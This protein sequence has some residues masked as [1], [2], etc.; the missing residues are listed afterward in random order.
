MV[1]EALHPRFLVILLHHNLQK[2]SPPSHFFFEEKKEETRE[3]KRKQNWI[4]ENEYENY[5]HL[6]LFNS[7]PF[8]I[9]S[10]ERIRANKKCFSFLKK[11]KQ[12]VD[13]L[14][15]M[16]CWVKHNSCDLGVFVLFR[17]FEVFAWNFASV[18]VLYNQVPCN[19]LIY[20]KMT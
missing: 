11:G 9:I 17:D 7:A 3:R 18:H 12:E 2:N 14:F 16:L 20:I 15:S 10:L 8:S 5:Y 6:Y 13:I 1:I 19:L 4:I